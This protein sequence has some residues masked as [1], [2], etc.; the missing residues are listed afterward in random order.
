MDTQF[1]KGIF[2]FK[3]KELLQRRLYGPG[4]VHRQLQ[5]GVVLGLLQAHDGLPAHAHQI[6]QLSLGEPFCLAEGF[7][8]AGE[9]VHLLVL[10]R[11]RRG[12]VVVIPVE[13]VLR[14]EHGQC[15]G[16]GDAGDQDGGNELH[17]EAAVLARQDQEENDDG[18]SYPV[19]FQLRPDNVFPVALVHEGVGHL[20]LKEESEKTEEGEK[21]KRCH[22]A[23]GAVGPE[24]GETK[25][26]QESQE[27]QFRIQPPGA[28]GF[29]GPLLLGPDPP[30]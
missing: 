23:Q 20:P 3:N 6:R 5:G 17:F 4:D 16:Q 29:D 19:G 24:S 18:K 8:I 10:L 11:Q 15:H 26:A 21:D 7:Q 30:D 14:E 1:R 22:I 13:Q 28:V 9:A 12:I 25:E 27:A 2:L